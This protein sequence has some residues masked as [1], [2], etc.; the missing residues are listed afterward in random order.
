[1][2][3]L[4]RKLLEPDVGLAIVMPDLDRR[5]KSF[6]LGFTKFTEQSYSPFPAAGLVDCT[7]LQV[8]TADATLFL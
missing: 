2:W 6:T 1:M 8:C 3:W 4:F 7:S 5:S